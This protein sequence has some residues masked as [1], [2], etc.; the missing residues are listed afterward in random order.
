MQKRHTSPLYTTLSQ[1]CDR[2]WNICKSSFKF[3]SCRNDSVIT[4]YVYSTSLAL[5]KLEVIFKTIC[6]FCAVWT[7]H[8]K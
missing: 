4:M 2:I 3:G 6:F 5:N 7:G 1:A 8:T